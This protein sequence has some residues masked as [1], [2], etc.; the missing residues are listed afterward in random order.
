MAA[1]HR[2]IKELPPLGYPIGEEAVA[3]WFKRTFNRAPAAAEIGLILDAMARREAE[4]PPTEPPSERVF[5]DRSPTGTEANR[6]LRAQ[7][8]IRP[9]IPCAVARR[10][11]HDFLQRT[12]F[13]P[14][15]SPLVAVGCRLRCLRRFC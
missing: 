2:K 5:R 14:M 10:P 4:Q 9:P 6:Y 11:R 7:V 15:Q 12:R 8:L 3:H 13:R 1:P